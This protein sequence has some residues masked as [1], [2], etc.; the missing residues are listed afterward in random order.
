MSCVP[1]T[2][3]ILLCAQCP[4]CTQCQQYT[5]RRTV[6]FL[7]L[8]SDVV[9]IIATFLYIK[10][11]VKLCYLN[12]NHTIFLITIIRHSHVFINVEQIKNIKN[13][14]VLGAM[15]LHINGLRRIHESIFV[16][17]QRNIV[18]P[19]SHADDAANQ[20][21]R[22]INKVALAPWANLRFVS[23]GKHFNMKIDG[24]PARVEEIR[25]HPK[26]KFNQKITQMTSAVRRIY[27]GKAFNQKIDFLPNSVELIHFNES[28]KFNVPIRRPPA[29]LREIHFGQW[30]NKDITALMT[31]ADHLEVIGF[32]ARSVFSYDLRPSPTL[33]R[34]TLGLY[35]N[36]QLHMDAAQLTILRFHKLSRYNR[37]L[38]LPATLRH[39]FIGKFFNQPLDLP[40]NLETLRFY[41]KSKFS[42]ELVLPNKKIKVFA[43]R[44][45]NNSSH[46]NL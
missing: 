24:L 46:G 31:A 1:C 32:T 37:P 36:N 30:F 23:F 33:R 29:Q 10:D 12:T 6:N 22:N 41:A 11:A 16:H 17:M 27:F 28:S 4:Q 40:A 45:P 3:N 43:A 25:F 7:Q 34:L 19:A 8:G 42:H 35:F 2:Q 15:S 26:S 9:G 44:M 14:D 39:L 21:P 20:V 5:A 38:I 13:K 18:G